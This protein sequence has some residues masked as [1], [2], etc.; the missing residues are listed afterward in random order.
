MNRPPVLARAIDRGLAPL[1]GSHA[2]HLL[3]KT[4]LGGP[5]PWVI[6]IMVALT[7]LTAG[8]GLALDNLADRARA[9]LAGGVTIQ[10][11]EADPGLRT[12]Q[13]ERVVAALQSE[14]GIS[15]LRRVPEAELEAL[16]EPWLGS[17]LDDEVVPLPALI[18]VQL[19]GSASDDAIARL[20]TTLS[21]VAP[22]ARI[23]AQA[24][25]LSPVFD[26]VSALRWMT[27][28]LI[29]LLIFTGAAAVWLAARNALN[30]NR[31]TIEIV[32]LLGGD[33]GQIARIF[34]RSVLMDAAIGGIAGL[35]LGA[36]AILLLGA[37]FAALESGMVARGGL[38]AGDW[39]LLALVPLS[40]VAIALLTARMTVM[41]SLR[42]ML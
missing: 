35:A 11:V 37:Q 21:Q 42:S 2:S 9:D 32:H 18:D 7:V 30:A 8:G 16:V 23:D 25:W 39:L 6:A 3:P 17:G 20:R 38:D 1:R 26:T 10:I 40:M 27:L 36:I 41:A 22:D 33:D 13:A 5:I 34:Q 29:G 14:E 15:T 4:R 12:A 24:D 31:H 28:G 19:D